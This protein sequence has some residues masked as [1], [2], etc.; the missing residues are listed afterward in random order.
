MDSYED[1][2]DRR[3]DTSNMCVALGGHLHKIPNLVNDELPPPHP[4]ALNCKLRLAT[5]TSLAAQWLGL[6]A[7]TAGGAG[8]IPGWGTKIPHAIRCG[9]N[10][11][12]EKKRLVNDGR[13]I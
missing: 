2:G 4:P 6:R 11:K 1:P 13:L 12:K 8:S 9:Q 7:S 5:G 3:E 10:L